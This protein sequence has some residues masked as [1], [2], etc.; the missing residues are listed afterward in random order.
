MSFHHA[1]INPCNESFVYKC[2]CDFPSEH[3]Q[4]Q[5]KTRTK[6][7]DQSLNSVTQYCSNSSTRHSYTWLYTYTHDYTHLY[8]TIYIYTWVYTHNILNVHTKS[9]VNMCSIYHRWTQISYDQMIAT[10]SVAKG[11]I[12]FHKLSLKLWSS[13]LK[14]W[15]I[16]LKVQW[17]H[18]RTAYIPYSPR[19]AC[20][21]PGPGD[22]NAGA[23]A[24]MVLN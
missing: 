5:S 12:Y 7:Y 9:S 10:I 14:I 8:M 17:H 24:G 19:Y 23:S 22:N 20:R 3:A 21:W 13:L 11:P 18:I 6:I 15:N 1:I 2:S 16:L 4:N